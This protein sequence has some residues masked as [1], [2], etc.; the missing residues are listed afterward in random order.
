MIVRPEVAGPGQYGYRVRAPQTPGPV[1]RKADQQ[2]E[3]PKGERPKGERPKGERPKGE[4]PKGERPK[5][6]RPKGERHCR[7]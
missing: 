1:G 5:G 2:G 6:E 7:W 4:R 3:R